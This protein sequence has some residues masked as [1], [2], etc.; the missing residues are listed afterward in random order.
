[1]GGWHRRQAPAR[2]CLVAAFMHQNPGCPALHFQAWAAAWAPFWWS[3]CWRSCRPRQTRPPRCT[4]RGACWRRGGTGRES[5]AGA[6]E[7]GG[8]HAPLA[9]HLAHRAAWRCLLACHAQLKSEL[10]PAPHALLQVI[11]P[12]VYRPAIKSALLA[13]PFTSTLA[14]LLGEQ[15]EGPG[16]W[17]LGF[18]CLHVV[19]NAAIKGGTLVSLFQF[20]VQPSAALHTIAPAPQVWWWASSLRRTRALRPATCA[21]C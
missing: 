2:A 15:G 7:L 17:Q 1:M 14:Q 11:V 10:R 5:W 6:S 16:C 4:M 8:L 21:P 3:R 12:L 19:S 18:V 20:T 13:A 9:A